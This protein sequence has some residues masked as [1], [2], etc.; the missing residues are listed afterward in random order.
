MKNPMKFPWLNP[1][2]CCP[3]SH[4]NPRVSWAPELRR[5]AAGHS[6]VDG[7]WRRRV[8]LCGG[9]CGG[10]IFGVSL[11]PRIVIVFV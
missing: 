8:G 5:S 2:K 6:P 4:E 3:E 11:W 9:A 1:I 10:M 7:L